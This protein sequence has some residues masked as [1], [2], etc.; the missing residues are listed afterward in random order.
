MLSRL[1]SHLF[2]GL[3]KGFLKA[4]FRCLHMFFWLFEGFLQ[5][6]QR[7]F[8]SLLH[9]SQKVC[10]GIWPQSPNGARCNPK[11]VPWSFNRDPRG[12][13]TV[14]REPQE[15]PRE[16]Q[17]NQGVPRDSQ[18]SPTGAQNRSKRAPRFIFHAFLCFLMYRYAGWVFHILSVL[19]FSP[20]A[21]G[22]GVFHFYEAVKIQ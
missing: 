16:F 11:R 15:G 1:F 12:A 2:K 5:V 7:F 17:G 14:L 8:Q 20:V 10:K 21:S 9:T 18:E 22:L 3:F 13:K 19:Y 6:V 4:F